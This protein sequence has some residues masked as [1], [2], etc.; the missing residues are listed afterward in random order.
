MKRCWAITRSLNRCGRIGPWR[1]FCPEHRKQ[2]IVWLFVL[3]FTV[4]AGTA[5]ILGY[6]S[7]LPHPVERDG[8]HNNEITQQKREQLFQR[9]PNVRITYLRFENTILLDQVMNG[10][11]FSPQE[12]FSTKP[13]WLKNGVYKDLSSIL[14]SLTGQRTAHRAYDVFT[15]AAEDKNKLFWVLEAQ[16]GKITTPVTEAAEGEKSLRLIYPT[17]FPKRGPHLI[18]PQDID[19]L[20]FKVE[21]DP[22]WQI[23]LWE[24]RAKP[25]PIPFD[26]YQIFGF[27]ENQ[28]AASFIK[29]PI[30]LQVLNANPERRDIVLLTAHCI[31]G[32][33]H[34][35][36]WIRE[37]KLVTLDIEN[38]GDQ[39]I[40]L[41]SLKETI[42]AGPTIYKAR[43]LK[44]DEQSLLE[45]Q[46]QEQSLPLESLRPGEHL[47][48]PLRIEL[49]LADKIRDHRNWNYERYINETSFLKNGGVILLTLKSRLRFCDQPTAAVT[50]EL[51][52]AEL[53]DQ[54]WTPSPT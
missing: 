2:P 30:S 36:I 4:L 12:G 18:G 45:A 16:D 26:G 32:D 41:A 29:D 42:T 8:Q 25:G 19:D 7:T 11:G 38:I 22:Y 13:F 6:F 49:G 28:K 5:S 35:E 33:Y 20:F 31:H 24:P 44:D 3:V 52:Y 9:I 10:F 14:S 43:P 23:D 46:I 50:H 17:A 21:S 48:I 34:G 53:H 15:I 51:M 54:R 1:L 39:P 27:P 40:G 37:I 47:I